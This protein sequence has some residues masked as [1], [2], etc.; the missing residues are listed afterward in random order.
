MTQ[1]SPASPFDQAA[2]ALQRTVNRINGVYE[3]EFGVRLD[4]VPDE[5]KL[6]YT[7]AKLDPYRNVNSDAGGALTANQTNLDK[8]IGNT[9]YDIGHLFTTQTAGLASVGS[10]CNAGY[11]A[12]GV[13]GIEKPKGDDFDVDYVSHEI[14]H[15]FGAN[16]TFNAVTGGCKE[17]D[18]PET[19]SRTG[20]PAQRLWAMPAFA[21]SNRSKI[22]VTRISTW[23]A[24]WRSRI[25]LEM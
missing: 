15:Q 14:G 21:S 11:K 8:V 23:V 3:S 6:I 24:F 22:I 16:H 2:A 19:A 18:T 25:S 13:T 12:R 1:A 17:I 10:V 9:N 4:L 20:K 7:D 5:A